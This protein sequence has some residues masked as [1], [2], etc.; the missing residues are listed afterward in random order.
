MYL[1][2]SQVHAVPAGDHLKRQE[3]RGDYGEEFHGV[4]LLNINLRL[5]CVA[6][7]LGKFLRSE[8]DLLEPVKFFADKAE[9]G[10]HFHQ[11]VRDEFHQLVITLSAENL[12][13][14]L[15]DFIDS[16]AVRRLLR[17]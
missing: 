10:I 9:I 8:N 16:I 15:A 4:I 6:D 5:I 3:N 2:H 12:T 17:E 7:F 14:Q 1:R 11:V 13:A